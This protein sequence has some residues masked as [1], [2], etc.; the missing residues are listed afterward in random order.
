[1][2]GNASFPVWE[3]ENEAPSTLRSHEHEPP[4]KTGRQVFIGNA[5]TPRA[6]RPLKENGWEKDTKQNKT[7]QNT[8]HNTHTTPT[9]PHCLL[10]RGEGVAHVQGSGFGEPATRP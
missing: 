1:M 5:A 8:T 9:H 6:A 3:M 7:K 2:E 4:G 10:V